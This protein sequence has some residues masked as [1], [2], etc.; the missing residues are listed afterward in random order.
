MTQCLC[1]SH[2]DIEPKAGSSPFATEQRAAEAARLPSPIL[3]G[4]RIKVTAIDK[5]SF[6]KG[7]SIRC[8]RW[9]CPSCRRVK[10][11]HLREKLLDRAELFKVPRL[12]TITI[13]RDW[14]KSP[15]DAYDWVMKKKF[16]ARLL[17]QKMGISRWFWVLEVQENSGD[18]WPHWHIMLDISDLPGKWYNSYTKTF[19]NATPENKTGWV[20]IRHFFDLERVH[21]YLRKWKIGEQCR[22]SSRKDDFE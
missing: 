4:K 2:G 15:H 10:G 9:V 21:Y 6:I 22:F 14:F 17:T 5:P 12:F 8:N 19:Q 1:H 16:I 18:G 7:I 3:E 13:N 20:F 11:I